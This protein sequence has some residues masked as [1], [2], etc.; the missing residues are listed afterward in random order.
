[1]INFVSHK[2]LLQIVLWLTAAHSIVVGLCLVFLPNAVM[3]LFGFN[4][5]GEQFFQI[6]GGVFHLVIAVAYGLA[7][8]SDYRRINLTEFA[9]IAKFLA[10]LFLCSYYI[11]VEQ[12]WTVIASA[13]GDCLMGLVI[14]LTYLRWLGNERRENN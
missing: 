10:T 9:I 6:Q 13:A 12:I 1:M 2:R 11:F 5:S 7:A 8:K 3:H 14:L 4:A